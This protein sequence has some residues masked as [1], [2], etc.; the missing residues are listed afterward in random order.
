[1]R[2]HSGA[3][4]G[5]VRHV[6]HADSRWK[7]CIKTE[8]TPKQV[9][10]RHSRFAVVEF[11]QADGVVRILKVSQSVL[12]CL[13]TSSPTTLYTWKLCGRD[14]M[15]VVT[16]ADEQAKL[17]PYLLQDEPQI[18]P[19]FSDPL[20]RP[21]TESF[22]PWAQQ[23]ARYEM[24]A[25]YG[26]TQ[27]DSALSEP[28]CWQIV[29][30]RLSSPHGDM[31]CH[32]EPNSQTLATSRYS[33]A[34]S[35]AQNNQDVAKSAEVFQQTVLPCTGLNVTCHPLGGTP[36]LTQGE[37]FEVIEPWAC[38]YMNRD[39]EGKMPV[40][41]CDDHSFEPWSL[42]FI[43][44]EVRT[45]KSDRMEP[46]PIR[47]HIGHDER[48]SLFQI[49]SCFG[50]I[51]SSLPMRPC[52][53]SLKFYLNRAHFD[54]SSCW[55]EVSGQ[56]PHICPM[57]KTYDCHLG[58]FRNDGLAPTKLSDHFAILLDETYVGQS[59]SSA[60]SESQVSV[61]QN[62]HF[63]LQ[64]HANCQDAFRQHD[65]AGNT[66][67]SIIHYW[68][69]Q[70]RTSCAARLT[71]VRDVTIPPCLPSSTTL[72]D[73]RVGQHAKHTMS[74]SKLLAVS[75]VPKI[76]PTPHIGSRLPTQIL[77]I[78]QTSVFWFKGYCH[79][80]DHRSETRLNEAR[81]LTLTSVSPRHVSSCGCTYQNPLC[82]L[83][84]NSSR[85]SLP[86]FFTENLNNVDQVSEDAGSI[87]K[88]P[89]CPYDLGPTFRVFQ[90]EPFV[91]CGHL[92][93]VL[94][95]PQYLTITSGAVPVSTSID[96]QLMDM[97]NDPCCFDTHTLLLTCP[98][99]LASTDF[100]CANMSPKRD[101]LQDVIR[102][103]QNIG[104]DYILTGLGVVKQGTFY[105]L[106]SK[107]DSHLADLPRPLFDL[108]R[109]AG[110]RFV[111]NTKASLRLLPALGNSPFSMTESSH[112]EN[113]LIVAQCPLHH[114]IYSGAVPDHNH[115]GCQYYTLQQAG[116]LQPLQHDADSPGCDFYSDCLTYDRYTMRV[117]LSFAFQ[118]HVGNRRQNH[119]VLSS[120]GSR[121]LQLRQASTGLSP[122][123]WNLLNHAQD[124]IHNDDGIPNF[125][126]PL[127]T[128]TSRG[129]VPDS[130]NIW[131]YKSV[132]LD[133]PHLR[134][135]ELSSDRFLP[136]PLHISTRS[137]AVPCF[138]SDT[139]VC[140][141]DT[142][143]PAIADQLPLCDFNRL[144]TYDLDP[145]LLPLCSALFEPHDSDH[146]QFTTE[147]CVQFSTQQ[148]THQ[149]RNFNIFPTYDDRRLQQFTFPSG[150]VPKDSTRISDGIMLLFDVGHFPTLFRGVHSPSAAQS[151]RLSDYDDADEFLSY[152]Q[153]YSVSCQ[154]D[155][156]VSHAY[157]KEPSEP[158]GVVSNDIFGLFED[159][160]LPF[161]L[162]QPAT[163]VTVAQPCDGDQPSRL[164]DLDAAE[165]ILTYYQHRGATCRYHQTQMPLQ[166]AGNAS[167]DPWWSA[168]R[169]LGQSLPDLQHETTTRGAV[170]VYQHQDFMVGPGR[171]FFVECVPTGMA[172][173]DEIEL[174][175]DF[176]LNSSPATPGDALLFFDTLPH[177]GV[178]THQPRLRQDDSGIILGASGDYKNT[179]RSH[180]PSIARWPSDLPAILTA[181]GSPLQW[182]AVH[183]AG[184]RQ[185]DYLPG[186]D[187]DLM[188]SSESRFMAGSSQLPIDYLDEPYSQCPQHT[189]LSS[190]AVPSGVG[191]TSFW[192]SSI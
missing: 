64:N 31:E 40:D 144:V 25:G 187:F 75:H 154:C 126:R 91:P 171:D 88:S 9:L 68:W 71:A 184:K 186:S 86:I 131:T 191:N 38:V 21:M 4:N 153:P 8:M 151:P 117:V 33:E 57:Y 157:Y 23:Y 146:A 128:T 26:Y 89:S 136:A 14:Q 62:D 10:H 150:A 65:Q 90:H 178:Y 189:T 45:P 139:N 108:S 72:H 19:G 137:G 111:P 32:C 79:T 61:I 103:H 116:R 147:S 2:A 11:I 48:A 69:T 22:E 122:A 106:I 170:P 138:N 37:Q 97:Q 30:P 179:F 42:H 73:S 24:M 13:H 174:H 113:D 81:H 7:S 6:F 15:G 110:F 77:H 107:C 121:D 163:P 60:P 180:D 158:S 162:R 20:Y 134:S 43:P 168:L 129:A 104:D 70:F 28:W 176:T 115:S 44:A 5:Y 152:H 118:V 95:A 159:N 54:T 143:L 29:N 84:T 175:A 51:C 17:D 12:A 67:T 173:L 87:I 181:L 50:T 167:S 142:E 74:T 94:P 80:Y 185:Y 100:G 3:S 123:M 98:L 78:G 92:P 76:R 182:P 58:G 93:H 135:V 190:G 120:S 59:S 56:D 124:F 160:T 82:D 41:L 49:P 172:A 27:E 166:H 1:M 148:R 119:E 183:V 132:Q 114:S 155:Q 53:D 165:A 130:N 16:P 112:G 18:L 169:S 149:G 39:T 83:L 96:A 127:Q 36:D 161:A 46:E 63:G 99:N 34:V 35:H 105:S 102:C 101:A 164:V 47:Q 141:Y 85:S 177:V 133:M 145:V 188:P 66:I 55:N 140:L 192:I 125:Q 52:L 156:L 109:S